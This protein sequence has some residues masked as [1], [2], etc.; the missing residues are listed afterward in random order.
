MTKKDLKRSKIKPSKPSEYE[1][2]TLCNK[3]IATEDGIKNKYY[4]SKYVQCLLKMLPEIALWSKI[5]HGDL[6][7]YQ[8]E[9]A[10]LPQVEGKENLSGEAMTNCH[11]ELY[12]HI[13][14]LDKRELN[15]SLLDYIQRTN[16]RR[17]GSQR[18]FVDA[19]LKQ[20]HD[21]GGNAIPK[22]TLKSISQKI[23]DP[24]IQLSEDLN[25]EQQANKT[26]LRKKDINNKQVLN[27]ADGQV[28]NS[29]DPYEIKKKAENIIELSDESDF[30]PDVFH[31][32]FE[33]SWNQKSTPKKK[34]KESFLT[35]P[36]KRIKF[37]PGFT[38]R[39][40]IK[41]VSNEKPC[42]KNVHKKKDDGKPTVGSLKQHSCKVCQE[43]ITVHEE[44]LEC[45]NC[46][47][48]FHEFCLPVSLHL[49]SK[50]SYL[51]CKDCIIHLYQKLGDILKNETL[52]KDK[53]GVLNAWN[54]GEYENRNVNAN[55]NNIE[56]VKWDIQSSERGIENKSSN[57][58]ASSVLQVLFSTD[59]RNISQGATSALGKKLYQ[60][61]TNMKL[62]TRIPL[63]T[64]ELKSITNACG[65]KMHVQ[66]HQDSNEF[67]YQLVSS[68]TEDPG[69]GKV[70][71]SM[72]SSDLLIFS[73]CLTCGNVHSQSESRNSLLMHLP[74]IKGHVS[75]PV[76]SLIWSTL[77]AQVGEGDVFCR[78]CNTRS[79]YCQTIMFDKLPEVLHV[80][81]ERNHYESVTVSS[82]RIELEDINLSYHTLGN[83]GRE[84]IP[85][86]LM[87]IITRTGI[88]RDV[89]YGHNVAYVFL[90]DKVVEFDDKKVKYHKISNILNSLNIQRS[91]H[92]V[93]YKRSNRIIKEEGKGGE[94]IKEMKTTE[95]E[96]CNDNRELDVAFSVFRKSNLH[97]SIKRNILPSKIK[98]DKSWKNMSI[99]K[100]LKFFKETPISNTKLRFCVCN[101]TYNKSTETSSMVACDICDEWYHTKCLGIES[102]FAHSVPVYVCKCC[103]DKIFS[104]FLQFLRYN[105]YFLLENENIDFSQ[106]FDLFQEYNS[107]TKK[108][109]KFHQFPSY[110]KGSLPSRSISKMQM[111]ARSC[112]KDSKSESLS[113]VLQIL[114]GSSLCYFLPN[115]LSTNTKLNGHLSVLKQEL[116]NSH[117]QRGPGSSISI[118]NQI[119]DI[120]QIDELNVKSSSSYFL[121]SI[122]EKL[123]EEGIEENPFESTFAKVLQ[124]QK[125]KSLS[126]GTVKK[127][128]INVTLW[129]TD[130]SGEMSL[131]S[132]LWGNLCCDV[133][134]LL[135]CSKCSEN[136]VFLTN[137]SFILSPLVMVINIQSPKSV[138]IR[139]HLPIPEKLNIQSHM[140]SYQEQISEVS[141]YRLIGTINNDAF[142]NEK[143]AS[144]YS[145]DEKVIYHISKSTITKTNTFETEDQKAGLLFFIRS[146]AFAEPKISKKEGTLLSLE[147]M[148]KIDDVLFG[149]IPENQLTFDDVFSCVEPK[150]INDNI[151]S[152][153]LAWLRMSFT[154]VREFSSFFYAD[155]I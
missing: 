57:C 16:K 136:T 71:E 134:Q 49:A 88:G 38:H 20:E 19:Y 114:L 48:L 116:Q 131:P 15:T 155:I 63:S 99:K 37:M 23:M 51:C 41:K 60:F 52:L 79:K 152:Y 56:S 105:L 81:V 100:T 77:T 14:K 34:R 33:E 83:V 125:C 137:L 65:I 126:G 132:L 12:F 28:T 117:I 123:Y 122:I 7:R 67:L 68:L 140:I 84:D 27:N 110:W 130:R 64:V 97:D 61:F 62:K 91:V 85:Y 46:C 127:N 112:I 39:T 55:F 148:K 5:F 129:P 29:T 47:S 32:D 119:L 3:E 144:V 82:T 120:L 146:D 154:D 142:G 40:D 124:C 17:L 9:H 18:L 133:S 96:I 70:V 13:K 153:F 138:N 145:E 108:I 109:C 59:L 21:S 149:N 102:S 44:M 4:M 113:L 104:G 103:I 151:V 147:E 139:T 35:P 2:E 76:S 93:V 135:Y 8:P 111:L 72:F 42:T 118:F 58:W 95:Y 24:S 106:L 6:T 75:I 89:N 74:K 30:C 107:L 73:R 92:A 1:N 26:E 31:E 11:A 98:V 10:V 43:N 87:A 86:D 128:V 50:T 115:I 121:Q 66:Q 90:P 36:S 54:L 69:V 94:I 143:S 78:T 25:Q 80:M 101:K 141:T 53:T 150:W 22:R 45:S